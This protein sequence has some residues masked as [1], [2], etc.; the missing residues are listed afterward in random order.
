MTHLAMVQ[1]DDEGIPA[2]W[3]DPVSDEEYEAA[4]AV[5]D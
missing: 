1:V 5:G 3:G 4:P 2:I